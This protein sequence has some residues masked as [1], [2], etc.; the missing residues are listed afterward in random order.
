[1]FHPWSTPW[2]VAHE[3]R[4]VW[5][6]VIHHHNSPPCSLSSSLPHCSVLLLLLMP[7]RHSPHNPPHKQLLMRLGVGGVSSVTSVDGAG[8]SCRVLHWCFALGVGTMYQWYGT[9]RHVFAYLTGVPKPLPDLP[10]LTETPH[11]PFGWGGGVVR[12]GVGMGCAI[13][14]PI[15][16]SSMNPKNE[17]LQLVSLQKEE[18]NKTKKYT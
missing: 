14:A 15:I 5:C 2:A 9:N 1:L 13:L 3:A 8:I 11:I 6:V 4:A 10:R 12:V 17:R 16:T 7:H 18:M